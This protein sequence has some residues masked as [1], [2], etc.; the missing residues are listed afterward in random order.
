MFR[1]WNIS[2]GNQKA[3]AWLG[4]VTVDAI[5]LRLSCEFRVQCDVGVALEQL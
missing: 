2:S 1:E 3:P 4:L 5:F